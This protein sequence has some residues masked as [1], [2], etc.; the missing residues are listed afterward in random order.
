MFCRKNLNDRHDRC[1]SPLVVF[2][3]GFV[4]GGVARVVVR[5]GGAALVGVAVAVAALVGGG[6]VVGV[7]AA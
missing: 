1:P 3:V 2:V 5:V 6:V 7:A 4:D